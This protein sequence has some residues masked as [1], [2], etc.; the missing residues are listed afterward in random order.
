ME[1]RKLDDSGP[2]FR[3]FFGLFPYFR[4]VTFFFSQKASIEEQAKNQKR[5]R[6]KFAAFHDEQR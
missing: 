1:F 6:K 5:G 4:T 3:T 2:S